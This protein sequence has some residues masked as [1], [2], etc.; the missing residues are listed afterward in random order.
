MVNQSQK[1][2]GSHYIADCIRNFER[3]KC[4]ADRATEQLE[5]YQIHFVLDND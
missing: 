2:T 1:E 5:D 3:L 4:L